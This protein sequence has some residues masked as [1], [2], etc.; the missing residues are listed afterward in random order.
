[1]CEAMQIVMVRILVCYISNIFWI[2]GAFMRVCLSD[3]CVLQNSKKI[4]QISYKGENYTY[5]GKF[6][7]GECAREQ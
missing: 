2:T 4:Y 1:M 3:Y 7:N 5:L 6:S